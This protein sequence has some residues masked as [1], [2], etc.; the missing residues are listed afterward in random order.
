MGSLMRLSDVAVLD[1]DALIVDGVAWPSFPRGARRAGT[2][3][4]LVDGSLAHVARD[5]L[6]ER[7]EVA[8]PR[9]GVIGSI[10]VRV[11]GGWWTIRTGDP[12][13]LPERPEDAEATLADIGAALGEEGMPWRHTASSLAGWVGRQVLPWLGARGTRLGDR[14]E[15]LWRAA[16]HPGPMIALRGGSPSAVQWDRQ[17]AYLYAMDGLDIPSAWSA[18]PRDWPS[19]AKLQGAC[20]A[21]VEVPDAVVGPLPV[22]SVG[23]VTWPVGRMF[24]SWPIPWLRHAVETYGVRIVRIVDS[25]VGR[26]AFSLGPLFERFAAVKHA[27]LRKLLYTRWWARW[28]SGGWWTGRRDPGPGQGLTSKAGIR[29]TA[30]PIPARERRRPEVSALVV[31]RAALPVVDY[32]CQS[33]G[34]ACLSHVDAVWVDSDASPPGNGWARKGDGPLRVWGVG[35]YEHSGRVACQGAPSWYHGDALLQWLRRRAGGAPGTVLSREWVGGSMPADGPEVTSRALR[36]EVPRTGLELGYR[37]TWQAEDEVG[38]WWVRPDGTV[39]GGTSTTGG[40]G[41]DI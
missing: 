28:A 19:L 25:V 10:R 3:T 26:S 38:G 39:W 5:Y 8:G 41:L 35:C 34:K 30:P 31:A 24:G 18:G 32:L 23:F 4:Y 36:M 20:S 9:A 21:V 27:K 37:P 33:G 22:R 15:P 13:G 14:W 1:D 29:W 6:T 2:T 17:G 7:D 16:M 40:K 11:E 12:W